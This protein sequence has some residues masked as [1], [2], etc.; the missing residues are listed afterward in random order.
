[1]PDA[2]D[3]EFQ[4]MQ[5]VYSALA[6]LEEDARSRVLEYVLRRQKARFVLK[7]RGHP[8]T[9]AKAPE[10]AVGVV[11]ELVASLVRSVY[12]SGSLSTHVTSARARVKQLKM[13]VNTVLAELLQVHGAPNKPLPLRVRVARPQVNGLVNGSVRRLTHKD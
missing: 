9:A 13:Y 2:D 4:A 12:Q 6:S 8:D 3:R 5:T 1:M 7:S 11:E 10:A